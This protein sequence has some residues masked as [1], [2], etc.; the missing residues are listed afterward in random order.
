MRFKNGVALLALSCCMSAEGDA[1]TGSVTADVAE[2]L[3]EAEEGVISFI[4]AQ[5]ALVKSGAAAEGDLIE[6][7]VSSAADWLK[8][9]SQQ[10]SA[11]AQTALGSIISA[12]QAKGT[13][14]VQLVSSVLTVIYDDAK[15]LALG[16]APEVVTELKAI[17]SSVVAGITGLTTLLPNL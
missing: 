12:E 3:K 10:L 14:P 4:D 9:K 6:G 2:D 13:D 15:T 5:I 11:D 1:P 16:I 7:A 8:G 17:E